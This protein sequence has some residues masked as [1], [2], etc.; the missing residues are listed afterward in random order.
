[1]PTTIHDLFCDESGIDAGPRFH[2]GAIRCS[3]ARTR[4][5]TARL[6]GVREEYGLT[7]EMKW[8]RVSRAMLPAY[9]A[10]VG[11]FLE[12]PYSRFRLHAVNR[13]PQWRE[14]GRDEDQRFFKSYYVFLRLTM[15][16]GCRYNVYVDDKPG[17]RHRW[18][19][20]EFAI[21]GAVRRDYGLAKRQVRSLSPLDSKRCDLLQ[22][23]DIVLGA[24]TSA[25]TS[26]H[27]QELARHVRERLQAGLGHKL[28]CREW[29]PQLRVRH[30][31]P[32]AAPDRGRKAGPGR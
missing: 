12:C 3:P 8:V 11:V 32:G 2:F 26:P 21:N 1:M 6:A 27:K 31:E 10:F 16:L 20:V 17:K 28:V 25:A 29:L 15:S 9:T 7:A 18:S 13:G 4:I 5:L 23:A 19:N 14:F 22:V 24:L 30:A